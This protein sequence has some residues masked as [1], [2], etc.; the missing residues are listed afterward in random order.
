M[1]LQQLWVK[2]EE[3]TTLYLHAFSETGLNEVQ[4]LCRIDPDGYI[5]SLWVRPDLRGKGIG[6][7]LLEQACRV[8]KEQGKQTVGLS[9]HDQNEGAQRL[10]KRL[11]FLPYMPGHDNYT[12]Y[13]KVL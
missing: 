11:G 8:L 2:V 12:Q 4:A 13:V 3:S 10:Y 9:V 5:L 7:Q 6:S 1:K